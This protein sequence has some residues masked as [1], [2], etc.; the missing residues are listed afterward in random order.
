MVGYVSSRPE[1]GANALTNLFQT[2]FRQ[3]A[4]FRGHRA[5]GALHLDTLGDD[6]EGL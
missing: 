4:H 1:C 2:L 6:V 3:I 5:D